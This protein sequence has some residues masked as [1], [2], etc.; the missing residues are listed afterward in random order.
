MVDDSEWWDTKGRWCRKGG[1]RGDEV[2]SQVGNGLLIFEAILESLEKIGAYSCVVHGIFQYDR[3]DE[4]R[5]GNT[6]IFTATPSPF[7][8]A[9][10]DNS[11][12]VGIGM[13]VMVYMGL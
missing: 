11:T 1:V 12:C 10:V 13:E 7:V 3:V 9:H 5:V 8:D 4:V 2:G 6:D